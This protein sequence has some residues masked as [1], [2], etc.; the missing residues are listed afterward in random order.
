MF[1]V[2][3]TI[4]YR[5]IFTLFDEIKET[6]KFWAT[7]Y[8]VKG[9]LPPPSTQ[10]TVKKSCVPQVKTGG[11]VIWHVL[12]FLP[13]V[14]EFPRPDLIWPGF[15][16]FW[17]FFYNKSKRHHCSEKVLKQQIQRKHFSRNTIFLR[18]FLLQRDF[19]AVSIQKSQVTSDLGRGRLG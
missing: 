8:H 9:P 16:Y 1:P 15:L 4:S 6:F 11:G 17:L 14:A 10:D 7:G 3:L 5:N 18:I 13:R 19:W 2:K 12:F